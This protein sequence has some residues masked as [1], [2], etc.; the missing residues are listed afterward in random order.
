MSISYK[1]CKISLSLVDMSWLEIDS[2]RSN[3]RVRLSSGKR[4]SKVSL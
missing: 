2:D 4:I 3:L 1:T